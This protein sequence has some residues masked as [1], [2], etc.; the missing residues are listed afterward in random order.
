MAEQRAH[1]VTTG[2]RAY[3]DV[4]YGD[5]D[6]AMALGARWDPAAKRWYDPQPPT[7]ALDRWAARPDVPDLL[8][9]E[10]REFGLGLFVDM[11][12][13]S[14]WFTNVRS[15]V[16]HRDWDRLRRMT[17]RRA[18]HRCE[19]CGAAQ[20][21]VTGQWLEV[22]ERWAYD[23]VHRVQSLRRLVCICSACHLTTHIGYAN[24]SGR[25]DQALAH[26]RAVTGMS[27][28]EVDRHIDDANTT[29]IARSA[30][31]WTLDL[32]MLTDAGITVRRPERAGNRPAVADRALRDAQRAATVS[33]HSASP[34]PSRAAEPAQRPPASERREPPTQESARPRG[35]LHRLVGR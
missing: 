4:P 29:W 15:C 30:L 12:P 22:H 13:R 20:D 21:R 26:L 7:F 18:G 33:V 16:E 17:T 32:G 23:V 19:I 2:E 24:V 11:V 8:P 35:W 1:Q 10:D 5:K 31:T 34:V 28:A 6:E 3:L 27:P 9:G 14:C 25:A